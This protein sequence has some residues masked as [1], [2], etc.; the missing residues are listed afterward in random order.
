MRCRLK[1]SARA[2]VVAEACQTLGGPR[3][4]GRSNRHLVLA[5]PTE[6]K[7]CRK[8]SSMADS[9]QHQGFMPISTHFI[10]GQDYDQ[11]RERS[12]PVIPHLHSERRPTDCPLLRRRSSGSGSPRF[13][14][15]RPIVLEFRFAPRLGPHCVDAR[16][17]Q[18][19]GEGSWRRK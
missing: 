2:S 13:H 9:Y 4:D 6:R 1:H 7:V 14:E 15:P 10:E 16:R 12:V 17:S 5:E 18:C 11:R 8:S 19:G 3:S